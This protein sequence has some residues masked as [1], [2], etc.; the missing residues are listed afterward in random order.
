MVFVG[1]FGIVIF[2]GA[3]IIIVVRIE[4]GVQVLVGEILTDA[5]ISVAIAGRESFVVDRMRHANQQCSRDKT[6]V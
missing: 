1:Q 3:S 6:I 5:S 2:R 4:M